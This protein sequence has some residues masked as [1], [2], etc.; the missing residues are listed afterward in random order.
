MDG[1]TASIKQILKDIKIVASL[2]LGSYSGII[3]ASVDPILEPELRNKVII[4]ELIMATIS[5]FDVQH[6]LL[7]DS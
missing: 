7:N 3:W 1:S 5:S 6:Q 2:I 4:L